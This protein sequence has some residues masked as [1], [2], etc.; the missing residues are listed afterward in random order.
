M[1]KLVMLDAAEILDDLRVPPGNRLEAL[2][3]DR[4]GQ[5]S[6]R[7]NQQWRTHRR[8]DRRLPLRRYQP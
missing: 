8:R 4:A 1:R 2:R 7:I 6:I 3:G 5:H